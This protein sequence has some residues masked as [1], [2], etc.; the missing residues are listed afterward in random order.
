[1]SI[2]LRGQDNV[3]EKSPNLV[4][5]LI[6]ICQKIGHSTCR[7]LGYSSGE[8]F[9]RFAF[10]AVLTVGCMHFKGNSIKVRPLCKPGVTY[11]QLP[12]SSM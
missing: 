12:E 7:K 8:C 5:L 2:S 10:R 11:C 3:K 4:I 6:F 1:M 9:K